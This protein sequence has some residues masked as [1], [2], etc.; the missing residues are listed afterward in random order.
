MY[1]YVKL[2]LQYYKLV[3]KPWQEMFALLFEG[4]RRSSNYGWP[5][6]LEG[7]KY[8][9]VVKSYKFGILYNSNS[10]KSDCSTKIMCK[11]KGKNFK[12]KTKP[13]SL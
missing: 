13:L 12:K 11:E 10:N 1:N 5:P 4:S 9:F 8:I 2:L 7:Q 3:I 6:L